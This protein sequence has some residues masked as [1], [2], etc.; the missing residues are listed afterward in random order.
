MTEA[1]ATGIAIGAELTDVTTGT[2][3]ATIGAELTDVTTAGTTGATIGAELT[4]VTVVG[5][6]VAVTGA[7]EYIVGTTTVGFLEEL[8]VLLLEVG[9]TT[10]GVEDLLLELLDTAG[11]FPKLLSRYMYAVA[12]AMMAR[13]I[14]TSRCSRVVSFESLNLEGFSMGV[15]MSKEIFDT[16]IHYFIQKINPPLTLSSPSYLYVA[17]HHLKDDETRNNRSHG[18]GNPKSIGS[19]GAKN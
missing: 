15:Y 8:E 17:A 12:S 9:V 6:R 13:N 4:D 10:T 11:P 2:T 18:D 3:G 5:T 1:G 7:E 19:H 16:I 14:A